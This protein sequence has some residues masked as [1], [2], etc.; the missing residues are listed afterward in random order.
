LK[1]QI[2][3]HIEGFSIFNIPEGRHQNIIEEFYSV[4]KRPENDDL[5]EKV[6]Y[7]NSNLLEFNKFLEKQ[8][9]HKSDRLDA[10][11]QALLEPDRT[12]TAIKTLTEMGFNVQVVSNNEINFLFKDAV[13]KYFPYS[14]WASG[15]S[16]KDGRGF[17]TLLNQLKSVNDII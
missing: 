10:E 2:S 9:K 15:K 12:T 8:G 3:S 6:I 7:V 4:Q 16:I 5:K 11:R 17:Q 1:Q 14:G 13:I